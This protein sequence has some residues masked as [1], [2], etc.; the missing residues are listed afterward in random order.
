MCYS[1]VSHIFRRQNE[2]Y[3]ALCSVYMDCMDCTGCCCQSC[4]PAFYRYVPRLY[5]LCVLASSPSN[6]CGLSV[7]YFYAVCSCASCMYCLYSQ[8]LRPFRRALLITPYPTDCSSLRKR[9]IFIDELGGRSTY[10][11]RHLDLGR[12]FSWS[13]ARENIFR[14]IP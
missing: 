2:L 4:M 10:L 6:M 12:Y 5:A 1:F 7:L 3:R 11:E 14:K 8:L 9:H 13:R